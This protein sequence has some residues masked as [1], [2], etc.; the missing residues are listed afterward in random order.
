MSRQRLS[1]GRS[2]TH[3]LHSGLHANLSLPTSVS[4]RVHSPPSL[5]LSLSPYSVFFCV[6]RAHVTPHMPFF[7]ARMSPPE[8]KNLVR[9]SRLLLSVPAWWCAAQGMVGQ[10]GTWWIWCPG[11]PMCLGSWLAGKAE[12]G[13]DDA[14]MPC[15]GCLL[16]SLSHSLFLTLMKENKH[17]FKNREKKR[18]STEKTLR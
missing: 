2:Q 3:S 7:P 5:P 1:S 11:Q 17:I 13:N 15:G 8:G 14:I 12:G 16:S 6:L 9:C 18:L 4:K 10:H